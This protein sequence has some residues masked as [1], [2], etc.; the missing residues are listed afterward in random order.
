MSEKICP[1][2]K[3]NIYLWQILNEEIITIG[4]E[5]W[6]RDCLENNDKET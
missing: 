2:C 3:G 4:E 5:L 1:G 6:H